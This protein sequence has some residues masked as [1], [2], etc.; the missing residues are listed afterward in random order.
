MPL[1]GGLSSIRIRPS[2]AVRTRWRSQ[3][4]KKLSTGS[5][6]ARWIA[7]FGKW[8]GRIRFKGKFQGQAARCCQ[9]RVRTPRLTRVHPNGQRQLA[10]DLMTT[11]AVERL[12]KYGSWVGNPAAAFPRFDGDSGNGRRWVSVLFYLLD[13]QKVREVFDQER[14]NGSLPCPWCGSKR[15]T[16][17]GGCWCPPSETGYGTKHINKYHHECENN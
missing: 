16:P 4:W 9:H 17:C 1:S 14:S 8:K 3:S 15:T 6:G 12:G 10:Q 7:R 11:V 2:N 5:T 13:K